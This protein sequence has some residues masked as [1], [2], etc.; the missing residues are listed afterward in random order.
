MTPERLADMQDVL[1]QLGPDSF[2]D[3]Q[4]KMR[5]SAPQGEA[6]RKQIE[7]LVLEGDTAVLPALSGPNM[8]DEVRLV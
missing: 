8:L 5:A 1:K 2:N 4:A 6:R 3:F 7:T